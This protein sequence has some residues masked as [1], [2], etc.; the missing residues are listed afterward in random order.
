MTY[1]QT[2]NDLLVIERLAV[3]ATTEEAS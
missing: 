3:A 2:A 1:Q